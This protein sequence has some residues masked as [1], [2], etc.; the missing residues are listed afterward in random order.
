MNVDLRTEKEA[1]GEYEIDGIEETIRG[2]E[3]W[4][5]T[6]GNGTKM[7]KLELNNR[8]RFEARS[9]MLDEL[10]TEFRNSN[11]LIWES[12]RRQEKTARNEDMFMM[13]QLLKPRTE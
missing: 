5:R 6:R 13:L 7:R 8:K 2:T 12:V 4:N 10:R 3:R 1:I 9:W 11:M